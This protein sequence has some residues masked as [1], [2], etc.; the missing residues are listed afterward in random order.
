MHL[1][2]YFNKLFIHGLSCKFCQ[3]K[4]DQYQLEAV[5]ISHNR[6]GERS[7]KGPSMVMLSSNRDHFGG[8]EE[9]VLWGPKYGHEI[10]EQPLKKIDIKNYLLENETIRRD[11]YSSYS[12]IFPFKIICIKMFLITIDVKYKQESMVHNPQ[13]FCL[14]I[15]FDKTI[16]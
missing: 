4:V 6:F 7:N 10:F 9:G 3:L 13:S 5:Q 14:L 12:L 2:K 16:F 1:Y 8:G 15:I 11:Y